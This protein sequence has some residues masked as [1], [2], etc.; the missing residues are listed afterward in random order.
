[1]NI[2]RIAEKAGVSIA[3]VSRV[4][5]NS[6][7]VSEKTR[8]KVLRIMEED[9]YHPNIFA[10]GL[11]LDTMKLVGVICTDVRDLFIAQTLSLLQ[12]QLRARNYDPLLFSVGNNQ[13]TTTK[14][15]RY[16]QSKHV[17]AIFLIGST[18]SDTADRQ[19][20]SAIAQ[21]I[22]VIMINGYV[23]APGIYCVCSDDTGAA[24]HVTD[25]LCRRQQSD[26]IMMYDSMTQGTKRKIEGF[27]TGLEKN[28]IEPQVDQLVFA[29]ET[30]QSAT[31]ALEKQILEDRCPDA[32]IATSDLLAVGALKAFARHNL[33]R[34]V[35]GFDNTL[36]CECTAPSLT[37]IDL[38]MELACEKAVQILDLI[39][40]KKTPEQTHI[41]PAEIIWRES[42]AE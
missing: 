1:M 15:L 30:L 32:V 6:P 14:H 19:K 5:N 31:E 20:L 35:I 10:R 34:S 24:A 42:F 41:C 11:M 39:L 17:D 38:H 4:L 21:D 16:L 12:T 13:Q 8:E 29:G 26:C 27:R 40:E 33:R 23:E 36:L 18:F 9:H 2:Y 28:G 25:L 3:T 7:A 22:P 37:S